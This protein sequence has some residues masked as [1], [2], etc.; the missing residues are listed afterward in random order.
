[1]N[2]LYLIYNIDNL[3][4]VLKEKKEFS[5]DSLAIEYATTNYNQLPVK[6]EKW[7]F[8]QDGLYNSSIIYDSRL[9]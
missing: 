9:V 1:M 5:D 2:N 3:S 6:I 8:V 4:E 7:S